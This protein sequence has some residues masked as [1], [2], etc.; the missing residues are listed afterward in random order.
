MEIKGIHL[1]M[2]SQVTLTWIKTLISME[3]LCAKQSSANPRTLNGCSLEI[4]SW[5]RQSCWLC[6]SWCNNS[7]TWRSCT[8]VAGPPWLVQPEDQWLT[9]PTC[10]DEQCTPEPLAQEFHSSRP[11]WRWIITGVLIYKYSSLNRLLR[12][13]AVCQGF[14]L[15]MRKQHVHYSN[16]HL[17]HRHGASQEL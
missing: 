7:S 4:C 8:V 15:R 10:S 2:D 13:T 12:I 9:Q 5:H 11:V 1:W 14:I 17:S 3:G 6:L 16:M